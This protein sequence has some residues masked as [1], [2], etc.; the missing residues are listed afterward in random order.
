M[1]MMICAMGLI[2]LLMIV[3]C[4]CIFVMT[5]EEFSPLGKAICILCIGAGFLKI[6]SKIGEGEAK[7]LP[8]ATAV[9]DD[10]DTSEDWKNCPAK[11]S[12]DKVALR[13]LKSRSRWRPPR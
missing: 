9:E 10:R 8:L 11:N 6:L 1:K 13:T 7:N 4:L 3:F 2:I 5:H 12:I